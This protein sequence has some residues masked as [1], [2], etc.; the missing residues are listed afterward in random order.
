MIRSNS[1]QKQGFLRIAARGYKEMLLLVNTSSTTLLFEK[2]FALYK[3]KCYS[4]K[5]R[6]KLD[7]QIN[8]S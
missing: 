4:Y 8:Y 1:I 3:E 6:H 7:Y 2:A 5:N